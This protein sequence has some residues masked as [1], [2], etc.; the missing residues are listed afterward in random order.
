MA[1]TGRKTE[2]S[3]EYLK[4]AA[5]GAAAGETDKEIYTALGIS[6]TTFYLWKHKHPEFAEAV[7]RAKDV[8]NARIEAKAYERA[9]GATVRR[10]QAYKVR[11]PDG[12]ERMEVIDLEEDLPPDTTM[13]QFWLKNRDPS[14]WRD[15]QEIEVGGN[16]IMRTFLDPKPDWAKERDGE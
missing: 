11:D 12:S 14:R 7:T 13:L 9:M 1:K 8:A 10:Q 4:R 15:K 3:Q 5:E 6:H 16:V 2:Y